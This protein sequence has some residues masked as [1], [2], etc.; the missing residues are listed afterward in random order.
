MVSKGALLTTTHMAPS[1]FFYKLI[2]Y[3]TISQWKGALTFLK[4]HFNLGLNGSQCHCLKCELTNSTGIFMHFR[5]SRCSDN[6]LIIYTNQTYTIT[7][8]ME[9]MVAAVNLIVYIC[10][11]Y[12]KTF[13]RKRFQRFSC[14]PTDRF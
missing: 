7:L 9:V 4:T 12:S 1:F 5:I 14:L 13:C 8:T 3:S 6:C 11:H 2:V 10:L